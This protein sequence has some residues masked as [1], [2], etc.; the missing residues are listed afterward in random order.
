[1]V[2]IYVNNEIE[3]YSKEIYAVYYFNKLDIR[4]V[5]ISFWEDSDKLT[6]DNAYIY[7]IDEYEMANWG[8]PCR[9][10]VVN[11]TTGA[12]E[13]HHRNAPPQTSFDNEW[14]LLFR[15]E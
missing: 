15:R 8:H 9:F 6:I 4:H 14:S 10:M 5:E 1:M 2:R 3:P 7:F 13:I 12:Y 11:K